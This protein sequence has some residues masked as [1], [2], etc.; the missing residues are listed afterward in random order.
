MMILP[1]RTAA[2]ASVLSRRLSG[3]TRSLSEMASHAH[4]L[5]LPEVAGLA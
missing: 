4:I 3:D 2:P 5:S 1:V